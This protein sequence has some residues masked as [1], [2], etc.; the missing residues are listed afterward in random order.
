MHDC[1][2][3]D[4]RLVFKCLTEKDPGIKATP[5]TCSKMESCRSHRALQRHSRPYE[6]KH[7]TMAT[8]GGL[9]TLLKWQR[10]DR[11]LPV[12]QYT[13]MGVGLV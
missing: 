8:D 1:C 9:H 4:Q 7:G 2:C 10:Y 13:W 6:I 3:L 11:M 12:K 5:Y